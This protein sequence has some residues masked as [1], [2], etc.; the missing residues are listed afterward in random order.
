MMFTPTPLAGAYLID[1]EPRPDERGFNARIWCEREFAEQQLVSHMVQTNVIVNHRRGTLRGLHYQT[2]DAAEAKIFRCIRG[3][4]FDVIV[5]LR[6]ESPT[7]R[8][9]F[10]VELRAASRRMLYVPR[11]F[12]Q[13]FLTLEDDTELMYQ[14]SSFYTPAAERGIRYDDAAFGI[15]WPLPPAVISK[16]DAS[17]PDF[18]RAGREECA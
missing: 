15:A 6:E 3:A 16:K 8:S 13:G 7:Y 1:P 4:I 11:R 10:G 18:D 2:G 12:A 17:W 9:W 14:V 5:D